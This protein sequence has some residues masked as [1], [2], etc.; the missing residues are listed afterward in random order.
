MRVNSVRSHIIGAIISFSE[1]KVS[2]RDSNQSE[3]R[4]EEKFEAKKP[5]KAGFFLLNVDLHRHSVSHVD[6]ATTGIMGVWVKC[7]IHVNQWCL[8][9]TGI[10]RTDSDLRAIA[11]EEHI[12]QLEVVLHVD[13][14]ETIDLR[15]ETDE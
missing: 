13:R 11:V 10:L 6:D 8:L 9:V 1:N 14:G 3:S 2:E 7:P 4:D 15:C 12:R 5:A